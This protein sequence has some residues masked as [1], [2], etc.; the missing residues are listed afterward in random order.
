MATVSAAGMLAPVPGSPFAAGTQP[1]SLAFSPSGL[2]LA[3]LTGSTGAVQV[4]M[5]SVSPAGA[6]L[7][8]PGSPFPVGTE[9][10]SIAFSPSGSFLA[11]T[12][13]GSGS[14]PGSVSVFSVA[15]TGALSPAPVSSLATGVGPTAVTFAPDGGLLA[16]ANTDSSS[17]SMFSLSATG[18]LAAVPG[19]PFATSGSAPDSLAFS[20]NGGLVAVAD[21]NL[22]GTGANQMDANLEVFALSPA[23]A[24]SPVPGSPFTTGP[25]PQQV[26]FS[27]DGL[28]IATADFDRGQVSVSAATPFAAI[29]SPAAGGRYQLHQ[30]VA[31]ESGCQENPLGPGIAICVRSAGALVDTSTL[32]AHTFT[33]TAT[34]KDGLSTTTTV[35]YTVVLPI[36]QNI[37]RPVI[38]GRAR[39][40]ARLQ[41]TTGTWNP[42]DR[43][44]YSYTWTRDGVPITGAART[45]IVRKRDRG[46]TLTCAVT[47][48][49]STGHSRPAASNSVH[50][51]H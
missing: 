37:R 40:G 19:S 4:S 18:A 3:V 1:R 29:S 32:G 43:S 13:F 26:A 23:G 10:A 41:C 25:G 12:E 2:L 11:V 39:V 42:P 20:P 50:V 47:A 5:F 16:V 8:I 17:V 45:Y 38:L 6:L 35:T 21:N 44:R 34:S 36:P 30:H 22:I 14:T 48:T 24:L 28:L 49:N 31:S 9:P 46:K 51:S 33:L 7:P 15:T 27:P